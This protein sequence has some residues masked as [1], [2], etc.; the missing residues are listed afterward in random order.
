ML[1]N[2]EIQV[3]EMISNG[4]I[5]K[6]IAQKMN[7]AYGTVHTLKHRISVKMNAHN[8][9]DIT[10][11]YLTGY[12]NSFRQ[13]ISTAYKRGCK[14]G[15]VRGRA[16]KNTDQPTSGIPNLRKITDR[17]ITANRTRY[18]SPSERKN[19]VQYFGNQQSYKPQ[20]PMNDEIILK[21]DLLMWIN[22]NYTYAEL[23]K[24]VEQLKLMKNENG[25][26]NN[27]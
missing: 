27:D 11:N 21:I 6:E 22:T 2:R 13:R 19:M 10:R 3:A 9:A 4:F 1:T 14:R 20:C 23:V 8:I 15:I 24:L 17:K 16:D 12:D 25:R 7:I 5:E 26:D 18:P